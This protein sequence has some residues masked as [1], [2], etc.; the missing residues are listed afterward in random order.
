MTDIEL[1]RARFILGVENQKRLMKR[2][3]HRQ[4]QGYEFH[5][6]DKPQITFPVSY[7]PERGII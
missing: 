6:E 5:N 7:N 2:K 3:L 1:C 4:L